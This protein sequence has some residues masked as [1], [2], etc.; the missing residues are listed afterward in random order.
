MNKN[1][2]F[3]NLSMGLPPDLTRLIAAGHRAEANARIAACQ[4]DPGIPAA[5]KRGLRAAGLMLARLDEDFTL[6]TADTLALL[7][8]DIPDFTEEE[9]D[10]LLAAGRLDWRWLD[11]ERRYIDTAVDSLRLYPDMAARG[12]R[13]PNPDD[14]LRDKVIAA[15]ARS[16]RLGADI[17]LCA[18]IAPM[19][20][21]SPD[22]PATAWLPI[23]ADCGQQRDIQILDA[24]PG[25]KIAPGDA[26]QR[27]IFWQ[28]RAGDA[29]FTVTYRYHIEAPLVPLY[30][31][32]QTPA[33]AHPAGLDFTAELAQEAPHILFTPYLRALAE[34]ITAGCTGGLYMARAIYDYVTTHIR[35]RYQPAYACLPAIAENCAK[36]GW[37]DCGVMALL[38]ITLCRIVGIPA[39]WQSGLYVTPREAGCHDWA[40]FY[41]PGYG[42]LWADCSFGA[43]A[44]RMGNE[45]RRRHY[46]GNLDPLRMV[47]NRR[48]YAPLSPP[49]TA[50]RNDPYDNQTGELALDG[51][52]LY[53]NERRHG[54]TVLDF[55]FSDEV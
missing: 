29:P 47:A 45:A 3:A 35:Y 44:Y 21:T 32:L 16:G 55:T 4:A 26:P 40:Q 34:E 5:A 10:A 20:A 39:R 15:M 19:G 41:L 8:A 2:C 27:T 7:R 24:T 14:G 12:L 33:P 13:Q 18:S 31:A 37:G 25:G 1:A 36:S 50:W 46:F 48:F 11:G 49:D 17:T 53:G 43:G 54:V 9:F 6:S 22:T 28:G 51:Q 42:W 38:F 52:G 23:P 30:S